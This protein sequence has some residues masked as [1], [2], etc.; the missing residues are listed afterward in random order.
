MSKRDAM[1]R[2]DEAVRHAKVIAEENPKGALALLQS[3]GM[4]EKAARAALGEYVGETVPCETCPAIVPIAEARSVDDF[5]MC[6][7]CIAKEPKP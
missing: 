7:T 2:I 1:Q 5:W 6:P 3:H 4:S